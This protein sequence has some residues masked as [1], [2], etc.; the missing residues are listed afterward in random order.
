VRASKAQIGRRVQ[1]LEEMVPANVCRC[2]IDPSYGRVSIVFAFPGQEA[3]S[4]CPGCGLDRMVVRFSFD[5]R[6]IREKVSITSGE[7]ARALA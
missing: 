1:R 5:P 4:T 3:G 2:R 7:K 6:P